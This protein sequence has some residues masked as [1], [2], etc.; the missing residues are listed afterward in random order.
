MIIDKSCS[1]YKKKLEIGVG[2]FDFNTKKKS[3]IFLNP[4]E[5][6]DIILTRSSSISSEIFKLNPNINI[7]LFNNGK[8][9]HTIIPINN[10]PKILRNEELFYKL[11][12]YKKRKL[13]WIFCKGVCSNRIEVMS[14]LNETRNNGTIKQALEEMRVLDKKLIKAKTNNELMGIEGN[15]AKRFY[16][17]LSELNNSFGVRRDRFSRDIVNVLMNLAHTILRNKIKYRLILK[18]LNPVHSFLHGRE[19]RYE[20]YLVWDF[21]ELWIAY[22]DKLIF[23]SLEKGIIKETGVEENGRLKEEYKNKI[24]KLVDERITSK[25]IDKKIDEF[26]N[27]LKGKGRFN[28]KV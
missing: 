14:R 1:L 5:V 4:K 25:E 3:N 24:I 21:A 16:F 12:K 26:I 22:V 13:A 15:I 11:P 6:T 20:D 27:Y 23:Y 7:L 28:W 19:N 9:T 8:P 18:G 17:C 10:I 2:F